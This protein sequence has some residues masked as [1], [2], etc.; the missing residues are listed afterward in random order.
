MCSIDTDMARRTRNRRQSRKFGIDL[1]KQFVTNHKKKL[2]AAVALTMVL[3]AGAKHR[4][5]KMIKEAVTAAKAEAALA[6]KVEAAKN[7]KLVAAAAAV[8]AA[9]KA[10]QELNENYLALNKKHLADRLN[11]KARHRFAV[12]M[13]RNNN[14]LYNQSH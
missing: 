5:T 11:L 1:I 12:K 10:R 8:V 14:N 9:N 13:L 4:Q 6:A 3:A 7:A 2:T